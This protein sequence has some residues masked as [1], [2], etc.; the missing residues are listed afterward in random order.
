MY[1]DMYSFMISSLAA[2]G[3]R[4]YNKDLKH[5]RAIDKPAPPAVKRVEVPHLYCDLFFLSSISESCETGK[6]GAKEKYRFCLS[7]TP[8][9]VVVPLPVGPD[10]LETSHPLP[11][12]DFD[13]F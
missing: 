9:M 3:F 6:V 2:R 7:T 8:L 13:N 1:F 5:N 12:G 10:H 4:S 11:C